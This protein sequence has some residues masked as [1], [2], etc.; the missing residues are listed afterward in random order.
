M[1]PNT[2]KE[3]AS[4]GFVIH[5][6]NE[7]KSFSKSQNSLKGLIEPDESEDI[8]VDIDHDDI[9]QDKSNIT[10][11][12]TPPIEKKVMFSVTQAPSI[13]EREVRLNSIRSKQDVLCVN[14]VMDELK[15]KGNDFDNST[16][17]TTMDCVPTPYKTV[18]TIKNEEVFS[19]PIDAAVNSFVYESQK[20]NE[21]NKL[22][23]SKTEAES[24]VSFEQTA[25]TK[26]DNMEL[27]D[28]IAQADNKKVL[29]MNS[30]V[31]SDAATEAGYSLNEESKSE[32][33]EDNDHSFEE[34][35]EELRRMSI[36]IDNHQLH[37]EFETPQNNE[38]IDFKQ[39]KEVMGNYTTN[40]IK[41]ASQITD[42]TITNQEDN[43]NQ[44]NEK[45]TYV[46]VPTMIKHQ[47]KHCSCIKKPKRVI[48]VQR[49]LKENECHKES[50][51]TNS[52]KKTGN[53]L[54][55]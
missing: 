6:E 52:K 40:D 53:G 36:E 22:D 32:K 1:E 8:D 27:E 25:E 55:N 39:I 47:P 7:R 41:L 14:G 30:D 13:T 35:K 11:P 54:N 24:K 45:I 50:R 31:P 18:E 26:N 43:S 34:Q 37:E 42:N 49:E 29:E 20:M 51:P 23:S 12:L 48:S 46:T 2:S 3:I 17:D 10:P 38:P 44:I 16:T 28:L 4:T 33:K 9:E 21:E 19:K 15:D 5:Q